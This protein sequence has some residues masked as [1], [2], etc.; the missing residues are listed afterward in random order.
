MKT[1]MR[2]VVEVVVLEEVE[3]R[4][5]GVV[6]ILGQRVVEVELIMQAPLQGME[7]VVVGVMGVMVVEEILVMLRVKGYPQRCHPPTHQIH[8]QLLRQ[9]AHPQ[10][11]ETKG[12]VR[13]QIKD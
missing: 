3:T 8:T 5:L 2:E 13:P 9:L 7:V 12:H 10:I 6:E 4:V 1:L 11:R